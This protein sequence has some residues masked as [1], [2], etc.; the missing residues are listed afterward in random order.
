[1][2][3]RPA[4][5]GRIKF[6]LEGSDGG[7]LAWTGGDLSAA[8]GGVAGGTL[9]SLTSVVVVSKAGFSTIGVLSFSSAGV[10]DCGGVGSGCGPG[11][12][13]CAGLLRR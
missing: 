13:I 9:L 8:G 12:S 11:R 7:M 6:C 10:G 4:T 1:M 3:R 5:L 2:L